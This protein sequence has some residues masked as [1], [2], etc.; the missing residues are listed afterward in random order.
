MGKQYRRKEKPMY[1][2][3]RNKTVAPPGSVSAR[4]AKKG[5]R[6]NNFNLPSRNPRRETVSVWLEDAES[7]LEAARTLFERGSPRL[8]RAILESLHDAVEKNMK[9]VIVYKGV[10][11]PRGREGHDLIHLENLLKAKGIEIPIEHK[12]TVR[13]LALVY[14]RTR[15]EEA[16][17]LPSEFQDRKFIENFLNKTEELY[18]WLKTKSG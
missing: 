9:A 18:Q 17:P 5:A 10:R 1:Q 4:R 2:I 13:N 3:I 16:G 15:Y 14:P 8:H 7:E 11:V 12:D 6:I